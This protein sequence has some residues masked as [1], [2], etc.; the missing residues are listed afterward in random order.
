MTNI[1]Y[2][3]QC[4]PFLKRG[5]AHREIF[6]H[7]STLC[8]LHE[9]SSMTL[10]MK[11]MDIGVRDAAG[12][13]PGRAPGFFRLKGSTTCLRALQPPRWWRCE[14]LGHGCD[15]TTPRSDPSDPCERRPPRGPLVRGPDS[16]QRGKEQR[17]AKQRQYLGHCV[18]H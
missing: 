1:P 8:S 9:V 6:P 18:P 15:V 13:D 10:F 17:G 12:N 7:R 3:L 16:Y 4:Y 2:V 11:H 5:H 14:G